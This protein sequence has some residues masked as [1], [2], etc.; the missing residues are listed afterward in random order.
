M[1]QAG[2]IYFIGKRFRAGK[3]GAGERCFRPTFAAQVLRTKTEMNPLA[4]P[5][6]TSDPAEWLGDAHPL[7]AQLGTADGLAS[8]HALAE[9]LVSQPITSVPALREFLRAYHDRILLP[10]ELPA[11]RN[12]FHHVSR[13][14]VR[15]LIAFD[16]Q[17]AKENSLQSFAPASQRIGREQLQKLRPLRDERVVQRYLTAVESGQA[18]GWHTLV[19]GMTLVLYSLPLRQGLLGYAHQTTRGFIHAAARARNWKESDCAALFAEFCTNLPIEPDLVQIA[20]APEAVPSPDV[21]KT[22]S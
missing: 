22:L 12:A 18:N 15:E 17:L 7:V 10:Q 8:L 4:K 16:Q 20:K 14:E 3:T 21:G 19:Y 2:E 9:S 6:L 13:N 5:A 1:C 11:I